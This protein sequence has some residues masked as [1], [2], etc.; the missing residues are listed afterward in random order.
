MIIGVAHVHLWLPGKDI[1]IGKK[2][3]PIALETPFGWTVLG[4][5]GGGKI[6][7][8]TSNAIATTNA[9]LESSLNRIFYHDFPPLVGTGHDYVLE[10]KVL[11]KE[12]SRIF[13][14]GN[15]ITN[16]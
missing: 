4:G 16:S 8:A 5:G 10:K 9:E 2:H 14:T 11:R 1:K 7:Q 6:S 12:K 13:R 15:N 3:E